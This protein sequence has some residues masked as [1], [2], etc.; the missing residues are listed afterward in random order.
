MYLL[1]I[2]VYSINEE[3]LL[4]MIMLPRTI[5]YLIKSLVLINF[6][7]YNK[8]TYMKEILMNLRYNLRDGLLLNR[9]DP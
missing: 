1:H 8:I 5:D 7:Y 9:K 6:K 3:M 4:G 2:Y